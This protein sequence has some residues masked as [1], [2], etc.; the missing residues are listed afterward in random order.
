MTNAVVTINGAQPALPTLLGQG[1]VRIPAGGKI[2]AGIKVLTK[3]AAEHPKAKEIYERGVA[4][5]HSFETIA[6]AISE[7]V[8]ELKSPLLP[9]NV[10]WFTVRPDDFPNPEIA[11]E[12]VTAYGEDR[13]DGTKR[14]YRFPVVFP[15]DMWQAVMP[16]ELIAW[17]ASE[18]KFW[19]EYTPDSRVRYC[20]CYAPVPMDPTGKR[21][22][23]IFGG[24]KTTLRQENGGLCDPELCPEYQN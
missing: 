23:R 8:P 6:R 15:A 20:K 5:N 11:T 17:G 19:S 12:I 16:H 2:R 10:P 9:K 7:A 14:L 18:K 21:A 4:A 13:G 1:P 22:I 3:K 24:R